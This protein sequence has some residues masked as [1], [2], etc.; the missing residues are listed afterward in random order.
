VLLAAVVALSLA[1]PALAH[2]LSFSSVN[3][4]Q[5]RWTGTTQYWGARDL[6]IAE[7]NALGRIAILQHSGSSTT[8]DIRFGDTYRADVTWV[9]LYQNQGGPDAIT[10]NRYYMDQYYSPKKTNTA[11]HELGHALGL[12]HSFSGQ[13]MKSSV[14]SVTELKTHDAADYNALWPNCVSSAGGGGGG[15]GSTGTR[16]RMM[17]TSITD[18][19]DPRRLVGAADNVFVGRIE[20]QAGTKQLG[21]YPETQFR[22]RV[23]EQI[24]GMLTEDAIVNQQGGYSEGAL[25]LPEGDRPLEIGRDY[26]FVT[27]RLPETGWNT[28]FPAYGD[29]LIGDTNQRA[30]LVASFKKATAEQIP[31]STAAE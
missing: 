19:E 28:L 20:A 18:F 11:L 3:N 26:L 5:I 13:V 14:S 6:A 12:D 17:L 4:C 2:F 15:T 7:W 24:K 21:E 25:V 22:V 9:G 31:Y 23:Q 10:F 8:A 30:A 1:P 27:R 16:R 29:I